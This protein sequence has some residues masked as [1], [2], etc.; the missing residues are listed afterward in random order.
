LEIGKIYATIATQTMRPEARPSIKQ[1]LAKGIGSAKCTALEKGIVQPASWILSIPANR[2]AENVARAQSLEWAPGVREKITEAAKKGYVVMFVSNHCSDQEAVEEALPIAEAV[3]QMNAIL[4]QE[5]QIED[6]AMVTAN[7]LREGGQ[8]IGER[9]IFEGLRRRF[10]KK[11]HIRPVFT[12]TPGDHENR[13]IEE[14]PGE[15]ASTLGGLMKNGRHGIFIYPEGSIR[16]GKINRATG[17][18]FGTQL[19]RQD[20][21]T[22]QISMLRRRYKTEVVVV[23][24]STWGA[25]DVFDHT[26]SRAPI[27]TVGKALIGSS[28][29]QVVR[30]V[31]GS[32]WT[33]DEEPIA[34]MITQE[35][36]LKKADKGKVIEGF[37]GVVIVSDLPREQQGVY[38]PMI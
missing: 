1:R 35:A 36:S 32:A 38:A 19:F 20:S 21:V 7:S 9:I 24:L 14:K 29:P 13:G 11:H 10:L 2:W 27:K 12:T 15:F 23:T 26:N 28:I 33:T 5:K 18:R 3:E 6:V 17:K 8:R 37:L 16:G 22:A 34:S 30:T 4:P 31:V 25:W